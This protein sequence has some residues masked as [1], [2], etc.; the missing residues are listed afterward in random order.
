[1]HRDDVPYKYWK[2]KSYKGKHKDDIPIRKLKTVRSIKKL[3][4]KCPE[5]RGKVMRKVYKVAK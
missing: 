2:K 5:I 3:L 1:M 4:G